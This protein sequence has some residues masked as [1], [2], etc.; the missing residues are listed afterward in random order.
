MKYKELEYA[1]T[2]NLGNYE[3]EKITLKI[4][5]DETEDID[6][7]FRTLKATVFR[8][9]GKGEIIDDSK[10]AVEADKRLKSV[11]TAFPDDLRNLLIFEEQENMVIIKPKEFLGSANFAKI[12]AVVRELQGCY[13]SAGRESHFKIAKKK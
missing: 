5:L 1:R 10:K 13:I 2:F 4:E 6:E 7:S 8:L 11:K 3:S 12:G 9:Q